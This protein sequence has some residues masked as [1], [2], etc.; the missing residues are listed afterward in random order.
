MEP[1]IQVLQ[2]MA[3]NKLDF[4]IRIN[5]LKF[6]SSIFSSFYLLFFLFLF[7]TSS[8]SSFINSKLER[9]HLSESV[10]TLIKLWHKQKDYLT[11]MEVTTLL[12][13]QQLQKEVDIIVTRTKKQQYSRKHTLFPKYFHTYIANFLLYCAPL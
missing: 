6:N 4:I 7:F 3:S 1:F 12:I 9:I 8:V 11:F 10:F 2:G 5:Q 13:E